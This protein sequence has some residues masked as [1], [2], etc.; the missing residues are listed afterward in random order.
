MSG[1]GESGPGDRGAGGFGREGIGIARHIRARFGC[2]TV[3]NIAMAGTYLSAADGDNKA[4][5]SWLL[6]TI[7]VK[8]R[9][10]FV[11]ESGAVFESL[12]GLEYLTM[13]RLSSH[14]RPCNFA[15]W[16]QSRGAGV[17]A[18]HRKRFHRLTVP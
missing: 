1:S 6:D 12:T 5:P 15:D 4:V 14:R 2:R 9:V 18:A 7:K 13:V 10:G 17:F 8:R 3:T 16:I 11:P